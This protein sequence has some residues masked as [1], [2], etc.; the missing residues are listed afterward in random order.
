MEHEPSEPGSRE[1]R[2]AKN[3]ILFRSVNEAIEE[4]SA[5]FGSTALDFICECT[6]ASCVDRVELTRRQYEHV[7]AEGNRFFVVPGHERREVEIVIE[8]QPTYLVVEK[9]D[10]AG[11]VA[12]EADPRDDDS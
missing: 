12:D 8:T 6:S 10:L 9:D 11:V 5:E 1:E 4:Q 3:E 2:L 7:R